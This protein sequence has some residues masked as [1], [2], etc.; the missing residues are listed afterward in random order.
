M[1]KVFEIGKVYRHEG[2]GILLHVVGEVE[3]TGDGK[4]LVAEMNN[5]ELRAVGRSPSHAQCWAPICPGRWFAYWLLS[6][7]LDAELQRK[8]FAAC[9]RH[10]S[11]NNPT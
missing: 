5:G 6:N 10:W 2:T 8:L 9:D 4:T 7:P 1:S 3:T 11:S